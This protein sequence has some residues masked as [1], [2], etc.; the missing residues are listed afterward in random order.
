MNRIRLEELESPVS[1]VARRTVDLRLPYLPDPAGLAAMRTSEIRRC[2]L[3]ESLF[4]AE[5]V[6]IFHTDLDRACVG[7]ALPVSSPLPLEASP[8]L[9]SEYFAQRRELGVFNIGGPGRVRVAGA[10]YRLENRDALYIP[11]GSRPIEFESEKEGFPALFY[12][13]S[14]PAQGSYEPRLVRAGGADAATLGDP[15]FSNCR[16]IRKYI[17]PPLVQTC[18]LTM[19]LTELEEGSVWNT[20]PAHRHRRRSEIY[21]YFDLPPAAAVFHWL[22]EPQ[23]TRHVVVR[24]RQAVLSPGWSIHSGAGT[25]P[26]SFIWSMGGENREF[27]D[28]DGIPV[29]QLA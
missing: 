11:K 22:G 21:L 25:A 8:E 18:Q 23:E 17:C 28:M 7:G 13:V 14:Y 1:K 9:G 6:R 29:E 10:A 5:R 4:E 24:N 12:F 26:Y 27:S 16:T 3:I 19:G 2:F 20:M 15:A